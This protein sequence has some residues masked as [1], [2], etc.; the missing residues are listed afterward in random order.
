MQ[1]ASPIPDDNAIRRCCTPMIWWH[2]HCRLLVHPFAAIMRTQPKNPGP[3]KWLPAILALGALALGVGL[4]YWAREVLIPISL[5]VL[6]ALILAPIVTLLRRAGIGRTVSV[7][8]TVVFAFLLIG[9]MGTL[10]VTEVGRFANDLPTY[11]QNIQKRIADLKGAIKGGSVKRIQNTVEEVMKEVEK[12]ETPPATGGRGEGGKP[13]LS[14]HVDAAVPA[15][16]HV[17]AGRGARDIHVVAAGKF[18]G[19]ALASRRLWT[20][21]DDDQGH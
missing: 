21:C 9:G 12:G 20:T 18:A 19:P 15:G 4:L 7:I 5:A 13:F 6:I 3:Y 8:L 17:R 16:R 2:S 10:V 11:Q 14:Q 1:V